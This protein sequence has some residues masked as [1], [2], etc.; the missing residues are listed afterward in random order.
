MTEG[1]HVPLAAATFPSDS[2]Y[3][4]S[5]IRKLHTQISSNLKKKKT[6]YDVVSQTVMALY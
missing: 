4:Y 5:Y 2:D 1:P 3:S 6:L